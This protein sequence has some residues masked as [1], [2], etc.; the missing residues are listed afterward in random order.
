MRLEERAR[1][2][3]E[4]HDTLL[5]SFNVAMLKLA[6]TLNSLPSDSPLKPKIDPILDLM[7]QG[8]TGGRL[9]D[10]RAHV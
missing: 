9:L 8:I 5:Q 3:R 10:R 2:A 6:A 1:I 7:E 4:L